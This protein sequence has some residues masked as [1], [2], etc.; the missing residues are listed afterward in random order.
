VQLAPPGS[1]YIMQSA[2][3]FRTE[4]FGYGGTVPL[5]GTLR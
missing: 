1:W 2:E 4:T 3:G 5:G